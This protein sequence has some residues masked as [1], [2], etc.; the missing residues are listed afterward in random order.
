MDRCENFREKQNKIY[1]HHI[2]NIK[3]DAN[4]SAE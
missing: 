4:F 1:E 2:K 3:K